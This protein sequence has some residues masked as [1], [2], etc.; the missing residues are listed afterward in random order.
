MS[1]KKPA[2]MV[3]LS[4][5]LFTVGEV[6]LASSG[7]PPNQLAWRPKT[8]VLEYHSC[9]AADACW[10]AQV[11]NKK[12]KKRVALLRCDGEKLFSILGKHPEIV[13]AENCHLFENESK[14]QEIP[15][16]LRTLLNR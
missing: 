15:K 6:S 7:N 14:F 12:T 8:E 9:G 13:A 4:V 3:M 10:V 2:V 1:A 11:K 16:A 5:A